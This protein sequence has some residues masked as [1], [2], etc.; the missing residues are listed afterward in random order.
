MGYGKDNLMPIRLIG[1][2]QSAIKLATNLV[3]YTCIKYVR[4]KFY[5]VREIVSETGELTV[6]YV[7]TLD[8]V[9][10]GMTKPITLNDFSPFRYKLRLSPSMIG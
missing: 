5:L 2:N 4:N 3:N 1:D 8:I 7:N 6:D 10:D 9:A